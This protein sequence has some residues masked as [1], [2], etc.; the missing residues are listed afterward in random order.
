MIKISC[1]RY[2]II[3]MSIHQPL[4][5]QSCNL[6]IGREIQLCIKYRASSGINIRPSVKG[7]PIKTV[8]KYMTFLKKSYIIYL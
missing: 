2:G 1:P 6:L 4:L 7:V 8:K 3:P 5:P